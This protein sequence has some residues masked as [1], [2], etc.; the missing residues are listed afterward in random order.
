MKLPTNYFYE[1]KNMQATNI[2][3]YGKN[4]TADVDTTK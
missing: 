1:L 3:E 2:M 4:P